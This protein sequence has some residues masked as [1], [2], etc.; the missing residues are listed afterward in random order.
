[1]C[2]GNRRG[3]ATLQDRSSVVNEVLQ[4]LSSGPDTAEFEPESTA[5][6]WRGL[7]AAL[8]IHAFH[9]PG[10]DREADARAFVFARA[11][12][13]LED[14]EDLTLSFAG[15]TNAVV[16]KPDAHTRSVRTFGR[17]GFRN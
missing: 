8:A 1:M 16:F 6:S 15:Y 17:A 3:E 11:I 7:N 2:A 14:A 12:A 9:R 10:N 5:F 13:T 4:S